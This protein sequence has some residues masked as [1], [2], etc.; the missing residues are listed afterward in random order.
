MIA[1]FNES[2]LDYAGGR[3][4][5]IVGTAAITTGTN[6]A[7][8]LTVDQAQLRLHIGPQ[9]RPRAMPLVSCLMP[10]KGRFEQAKLA[11]GCY[12]RQTWPSRELV[13]IDQNRDG[14]LAGWIAGLQDPT[15]R[16]FAMPDLQEPLGS[17]RNRSIDLANGTLIC[18]WDD[19]DL[20]HA[21]RLEIA[22]VAMIAAKAQACTL[23]RESVWMPSTRRVGIRQVWPYCNTI[24][25]HRDAGLRYLPLPVGEDI[26]AV[27]GLIARKRAI[28]LDL[29][30]LY[31]YVM[32]GSNTVSAAYLERRWANSTDRTEGAA[33]QSSLAQLARAFPIAEY[34]AI[35]GEG[36]AAVDA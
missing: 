20:Q 32:H 25:A 27:H 10:T 19:D 15:I 12:R 35:M 24:L 29:P 5:E 33:S 3:D 21:A 16:V 2:L 8:A 23:L 1:A 6:A 14:R 17:I 18:A 26:P 4:I 28:L 9:R 7:G 11:I 30:E 36:A 22:I 31:L 13:V 34:A